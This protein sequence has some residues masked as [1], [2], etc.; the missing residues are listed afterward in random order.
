M[1]EDEAAPSVNPSEEDLERRQ[2][3]FDNQVNEETLQEHLESQI[4]V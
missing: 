4:T 1:P 2:R 3:F